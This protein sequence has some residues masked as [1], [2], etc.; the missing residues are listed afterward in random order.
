MKTVN[1]KARKTRPVRGAAYLIALALTL[2]LTMLIAATQLEVA[3]EFKV[4]VTERDFER[5]LQM[6]EAGA[7][8]YQH[9]LTFGPAPSSIN[10]YLLPPLYE[11]PVGTVP[12]VQEFRNGVKNGT[13]QL[14][15]Y[16]AD[17]QQG[18]FAGSIGEPGSTARIVSYGWS[19]GVVR[20]IVVNAIAQTAP[21]DIEDDT[22]IRPSGEF[23]LF[24]WTSL[25]V[26]QNCYLSGG[27]G[28]NGVV[29]MGGNCTVTN[30]V[31]SCNG[32]DSYAVLGQ[33]TVATVVN[34]PEPVLWP[35]VEQI[36]NRLFP[37]GGLDWLANNNDN[38]L[39]TINGVAGIPNKR[40]NT[41]KAVT[42]VFRGKPGGANYYLT[43]MQFKNN[44]TIRFDNTNGPVRIWLGPVEG[45]GQF[46]SKNGTDIVVTSADP[47]NAPR[48]YIATTGGFWGKNNINCNFGVYAYNERD[49]RRWGCIELMNN[50]AFRGT[51]VGNTVTLKNN[52]T[53]TAQAPFWQPLGGAYYDMSVW[54][55]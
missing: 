55:E 10:G 5:A 7:N 33:N 22:I 28:T 45:G 16:P 27:I 29:D 35:T 52:A 46:W 4:S 8:A 42:V 18:Y 49:G 1:H 14:I 17:S 31:V 24:A 51:F 25:T 21:D 38:N 53:I 3:T 34:N 13:Y 41:T 9:R 20:R 43:D 54:Q 30:G 40:I 23:S 39:A 19:N 6:A 12:T 2:C 32:P 44:A 47:A 15:R 37:Q 11:F 50:M 48:V 26:E 36:A